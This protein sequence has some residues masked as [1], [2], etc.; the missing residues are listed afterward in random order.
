MRSLK[1]F[2][3]AEIPECISVVCDA[4]TAQDGKRYPVFNATLVA[5]PNRGSVVNI[6]LNET[7]LDWLLAAISASEQFDIRVKDK[8]NDS[9]NDLP[10]LEH[11]N[12]K[13]RKRGV[14]A[15]AILCCEYTLADGTPKIPSKQYRRSTMKMRIGSWLRVQQRKFKNIM[16]RTM[17]S[18]SQ[19]DREHALAMQFVLF[20]QCMRGSHAQHKWQGKIS[21]ACV[22]RMRSTNGRG[23]YAKNA[24]HCCSCRMQCVAVHVIEPKW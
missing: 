3:E 4:F 6:L 10:E 5:T 19:W 8:S 14:N 12:V 16:A 15:G 9:S 24:P 7:H 13:W 17:S 23:K 2:A 1:A 20:A 11:P 18:C 22:V 21:N